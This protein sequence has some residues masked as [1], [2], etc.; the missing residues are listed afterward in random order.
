MFSISS[1]MEEQ[2]STSSAINDFAIF[3][4]NS[5]NN[6]LSPAISII[7]IL[8]RNN[9]TLQTLSTSLLAFQK[10]IF[11]TFLRFRW[12]ELELHQQQK[13]ASASVARTLVDLTIQR[14]RSREETNVQFQSL[15]SS[16]DKILSEQL[17]L[18][19]QCCETI[20]DEKCSDKRRRHF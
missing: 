11:S 15:T 7:G 17:G 10:L 1:T 13:R 19:M 12:I 4:Q 14:R 5:L 20:E 2:S 8:G 18:L 6:V 9:K 3:V 16:T